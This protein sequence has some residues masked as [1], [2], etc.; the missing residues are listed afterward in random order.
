MEELKRKDEKVTY[1]YWYEKGGKKFSIL[2]CGDLMLRD[3]GTDWKKSGIFLGWEA[4]EVDDKDELK[5]E[6]QTR[7]ETWDELQKML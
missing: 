6:T 1:Q 3:K 2:D 5:T 4:F 7:A